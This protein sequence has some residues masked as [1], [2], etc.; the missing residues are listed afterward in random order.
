MC[1]LCGCLMCM[2]MCLC[3]ASVI[4]ACAVSYMMCVVLTERN[5]GTYKHSAQAIASLKGRRCDLR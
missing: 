5:H 3:G 1:L 4:C 2:E